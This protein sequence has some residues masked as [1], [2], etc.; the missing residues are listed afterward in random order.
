V[1]LVVVNVV[2][3]VLNGILLNRLIFKGQRSA[4]IMEMPLY[5]IPNARTIGLFVW[6]NVR[7]FVRKAARWILLMSTIVWVFSMLPGGD[8]EQSWLAE[9]GRRLEPV[10]QP[11]GLERLA[12]NRGVADQFHR[13]RKRSP[14]WAFCTDRP[15]AALGCQEQVATTL[16]STAALAF[17]VVQML[18]IPCLATVAVIKQETAS[19]R[20]TTYS[21]GLM[22]VISLA[23]GVLVYQV[24]RWL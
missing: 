7:E 20:W 11:V 5:H 22:L 2:I 18:F 23:M 1:G 10:G 16:T 24:G 3:L 9:L 15:L 21:V 4:F 19:W 14:R 17:L 6:H 8:V 12:L 13:Q